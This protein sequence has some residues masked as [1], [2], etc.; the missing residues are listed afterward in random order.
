L[1]AV[2]AKLF[3]LFF[4]QLF[5]KRL[6]FVDRFDSV[7]PFAESREAEESFARRTES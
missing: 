5:P 2:F 1:K 6:D 4:K 7:F 3:R